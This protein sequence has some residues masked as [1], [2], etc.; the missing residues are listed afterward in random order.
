MESGKFKRE[1][2]GRHYLAS[3]PAMGYRR[4]VVAYF[5]PRYSRT[6]SLK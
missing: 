2:M 6:S 5:I 4:E 3:Y 1:R